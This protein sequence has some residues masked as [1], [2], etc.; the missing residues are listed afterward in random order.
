[1]K[2]NKESR[3]AKRLIIKYKDNKELINYI[4]C[5]FLTF[6]LSMLIYTLLSEIFKINVLISNTVTW[7]IAVYFAFIINRRFVF[8]SNKNIVR[9]LAQFYAGRIITLFVE[10]AILYIFI[11]RLLLDNLIIKIIAQII[12]IILNYIISKFVVF[13]KEK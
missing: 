7:I 12:I 1:M 2:I 11:I 9:E 4:I 6:L 8:E 13:K 3:I 5:G 10:Q